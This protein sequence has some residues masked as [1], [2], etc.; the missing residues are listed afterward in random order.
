L[1]NDTTNV[2]GRISGFYDKSH[3]LIFKVGKLESWKV[4]K[5]HRGK[6]SKFYP[7]VLGLCSVQAGS[8]F[9]GAKV[10]SFK[11]STFGSLRC[12]G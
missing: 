11:G 5:V 2:L 9:L 7:E 1:I 4:E 12:F 8:G 3:V 6:G 10:H